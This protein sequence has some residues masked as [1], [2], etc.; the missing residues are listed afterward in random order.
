VKLPRPTV[1]RAR[2]APKFLSVTTVRPEPL[3]EILVGEAE[4]DA[5]GRSR[6]VPVGAP[7]AAS[8][9]TAIAAPDARI[10]DRSP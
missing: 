7:A 9:R 1:T 3:S 10:T 4:S 6:L 8:A 5:S 2:D